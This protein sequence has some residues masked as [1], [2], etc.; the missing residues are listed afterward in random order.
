MGRSAE[1]FRFRKLDKIG[2][3]AAEED[4]ETLRECFI[5]TGALD[6]LRELENP[7][8]IVVGGTGSGK[9]ALL[10]RLGEMEQRVIAV[11][12]ESLALSYI[13]NSTILAFLSQLGVKLDIFYKLLWRHVFV[14]EI[15]KAH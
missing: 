14:V 3:A 7:A 4:K 15:L 10:I 13:T 6:A 5:E 2:V 12:P 9:S 11:P 1:K 8:R